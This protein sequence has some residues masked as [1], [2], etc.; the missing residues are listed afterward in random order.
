[1]AD[2]NSFWIPSKFSKDFVI[3]YHKN[4]GCEYSLELPD[5]GNSNEYIQNMIT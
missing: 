1:M 3:F 2:S 5:R 4:V